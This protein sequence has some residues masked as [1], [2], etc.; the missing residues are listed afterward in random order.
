M[1]FQLIT[2][3]TMSIVKALT[4][5]RTWWYGNNGEG[6]NK[7]TGQLVSNS[8][9]W[10]VWE[11]ASLVLIFCAVLCPAFVQGNKLCNSPHWYLPSYIY[12]WQYS[13]LFS[14]LEESLLSNKALLDHVRHIFMS[15]ESVR[16]DFNVQLQLDVN[17]SS[18]SSCESQQHYDYYDFDFDTFCP[19]NS[20]HN[21]WELYNITDKYGNTLDSLDNIMTYSSQTLNRWKVDEIIMY[22]SLLHGSLLAA[23]T[24]VVR[25]GYDSEYETYNYVFVP[26]NLRLERLDCN[27]PIT[28]TKC[29]VSELFSWH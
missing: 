28:L 7:I 4:I 14:K 26:M 12:R 2:N 24:P 8:S 9:L 6:E 19:S 1:R 16:I 15:T 23:A 5:F 21:V 10:C 13:T 27:P 25:F 22:I 3:A 17:G 11:M 29:V 20:T 18:L